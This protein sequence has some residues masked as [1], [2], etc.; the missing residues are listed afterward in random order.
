M[1]LQASYTDC[2]SICTQSI[3]VAFA[4]NFLLAKLTRD[5]EKRN[6]LFGTFNLASLRRVN[7]GGEAVVS[8]TAVAFSRTLKNLAK[9]GDASFVISAGFGMTETWQV[10][11]FHHYGCSLSGLF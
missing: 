4:P 8:S 1:L 9:N 7:S 11:G 5:L 10:T 3:E 6:D 2:R